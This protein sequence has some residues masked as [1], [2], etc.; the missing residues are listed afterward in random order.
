MPADSTAESNEVDRLLREAERA[1]QATLWEDAARAYE[2]C[3]SLVAVAPDRHAQDEASLL[4]ALG[5]CYWNL[6]EARNAWRTLRRAIALCQ[7]RGDGLGQARATLE[8]LRIWGPQERQQAMA[9]E[10]LDALGDADPYLRM[11]LLLR[12]RWGVPDAAANFDEALAIGEQHRYPEAAAERRSEEGWQEFEAGDAAAGVAIQRAVHATYDDI[13]TY[14]E[15]AGILRGAAYATLELG[16]LDAGLALA[17]E[18][19]DYARSKHL[20]FTEQLALVDAAGVMFARAEYDR[21]LELLDL[22]PTNTDFRADLYRMWIVERSGDTRTAL[23]LLVNPDRAGGALTAISQTHGAAAGIL[24]RAGNTDAAR[25]ELQ[26]WFEAAQHDNS[27]WAESAA[28]IECIVGLGDDD[29]LRAI[30]DAFW[31]E[32]SRARFA[33]YSTLQGRAL[34]PARG[35]IALRLGRLDDAERA[36]RDGV[37]WCEAQGCPIDGG[38][39]LAGLAAVARA[40]GDEEAARAYDAQAASV[41]RQFGARLYLDRLGGGSG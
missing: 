28:L 7:E 23:A 25:Q 30:R 31:G 6:S 13:Q 15:A 20:R 18:T 32:N 12:L 35:A 41:F 38:L 22:L 9:R 39:C 5:R 19:A 3:L 33:N 2:A 1:D 17:L 34:A 21:C 36:Y 40:R 11:R 8:I 4:T 29:L 16:L 27:L 10:A 14:D 24:Y 26:A 37:A